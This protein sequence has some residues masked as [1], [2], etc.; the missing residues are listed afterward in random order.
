MKFTFSISFLALFSFKFI[1]FYETSSSHQTCSCEQ[2][3]FPLFNPET[4]A[5]F[6]HRHWVLE[7]T[8]RSAVDNLT[9]K[10]PEVSLNSSTSSHAVRI[11]IL[12]HQKRSQFEFLGNWGD[13]RET[14]G[15]RIFRGATAQ[16]RIASDR[17][18][19]YEA[20]RKSSSRLPTLSSQKERKIGKG[21]TGERS[22]SPW[23]VLRCAFNNISKKYSRMKQKCLFDNTNPKHC[24][25]RF[26]SAYL[27]FLRYA[28]SICMQLTFTLRCLCVCTSFV[29]PLLR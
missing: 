12:H 16:Q 28:S 27:P 23:L 25:K 3:D 9:R 17:S 2:I 4:C 15:R 13:D 22:Q 26:L 6:L 29:C 10:I 19:S 11:S 1:N 21:A 20:R 7:E 8:W 24:G 14:E 18:S 5:A